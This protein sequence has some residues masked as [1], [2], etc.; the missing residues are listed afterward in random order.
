MICL[1]SERLETRQAMEIRFHDSRPTDAVSGEVTAPVSQSVN[2]V[3][4]CAPGPRRQILESEA[5]A[6]PEKITE[7]PGRDR[8]RTQFH[9][10]PSVAGQ[11]QYQEVPGRPQLDLDIVAVR[12]EQEEFGD[13]VVPQPGGSAGWRGGCRVSPE[14]TLDMKHQLVGDHPEV[15]LHGLF[16]REENSVPAVRNDQPVFEVQGP[17]PGPASGP[18]R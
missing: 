4:V 17:A 12:A 14:G 15:E 1:A 10:R 18:I 3:G 16:V 13:F 5:E 8:A 6:D 11:G 9:R 7:N 2:R